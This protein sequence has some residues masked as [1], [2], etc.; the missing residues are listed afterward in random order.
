MAFGAIDKGTTTIDEVERLLTVARHRHAI[1]QAVMS[2][3][4]QR[5]LYVAR[6]ILNQQDS[7]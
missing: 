6:V 3:R 5:E 1:G 2:E 7:P 4:L